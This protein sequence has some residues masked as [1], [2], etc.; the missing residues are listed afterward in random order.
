MP[1][2]TASDLK[3]LIAQNK[4]RKALDLLLHKSKSMEDQEV[5]NELIN[6]SGRFATLLKEER[7][8]MLSVDEVSRERSKINN[9]LLSIIDEL[10]GGTQFANPS[11][12]NISKIVGILG[13]VAIALLAFWWLNQPKEDTKAFSVTFNVHGPKGKMDMLLE[14]QGKLFMDLKGDRREA[15]IGDKGQV[16]FQSIPFQFKNKEVAIGIDAKG[17]Q[18]VQPDQSVQ[19]GDELIYLAVKSACL[20]C[21]IVGNVRNEQAFV[22]G[23]V[24]SIG[25]WADTTDVRGRFELTIPPAQERKEYTVIVEKEGKIVWENYVTP[26]PGRDVEILLLE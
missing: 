8:G 17:Y 15:M 9:A 7:Q 3:N 11:N 14:N 20:T 19:L 2:H 18:L 12:F 16:V 4:T 1:L 24:V 22:E 26:S 5:Y 25:D 23:A 13:V 6:I 21:Q 10:P